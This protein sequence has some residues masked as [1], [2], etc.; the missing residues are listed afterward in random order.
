MYAKLVIFSSLDL[1][2]SFHCLKVEEGSMKYTAF[3]SHLGQFEFTRA[4]FGVTTVPPAMML[5][6]GLIFSEKDGQLMKFAL[7]YVDDVLCYSG[8]IEEHFLQ[9]GEIFVRFR[10]SGMRLNPKKCSFLFTEFVFLGNL[11]NT[12]SI[13]PNPDKVKAM[14]I[15]QFY[16]KYIQ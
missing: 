11:V 10:T 6:I 14:Q 16:K 12:N 9:L 2:S 3:E 15:F 5:L 1:Q 13:G 7:A 8:S 4:Q